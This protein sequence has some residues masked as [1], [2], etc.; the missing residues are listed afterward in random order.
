MLG[1]LL[2]LTPPPLTSLLLPGLGLWGERGGRR[3]PCPV[4]PVVGRESGGL[5]V[6]K[7]PGE[8]CLIFL[9]HPRSLA[10]SS[11]KLSLS[12]HLSFP[13]KK[14]I[15]PMER[16]GEVNSGKVPLQGEIPGPFLLGTGVGRGQ[17]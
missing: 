12:P 17:G 7:R 16:E 11:P 2:L 3:R 4:C 14:G 1:L 8:T 13:P 6:G 10:G 5:H 15:C 9:I